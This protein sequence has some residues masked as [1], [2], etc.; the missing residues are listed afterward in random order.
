MT[1]SYL[2]ALNVSGSIPDETDKTP[3]CFLRCVLEKTKVL[4]EDGE[5]DVERTADVLS[6]VRHGTAK[7]DVEEMANRCSDRPE[8]CQ[9]ERS[10]NYLKCL[11]EADL[12]R[13]K[14]E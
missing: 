5:F 4:S 8:K 11:I 10:Y 13:H 3:K 14:M 12:E 7:N 2:E 1:Q 6:M 9:C